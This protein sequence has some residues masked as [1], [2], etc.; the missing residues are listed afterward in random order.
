MNDI[1][2]KLQVRCTFYNHAATFIVVAPATTAVALK[3]IVSIHFFSIPHILCKTSLSY[4]EEKKNNITTTKN[5]H[6]T[7]NET[8]SHR[9]ESNMLLFSMSLGVFM[10][11]KLYLSDR[12]VSYVL[13][14]VCYR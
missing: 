12:Y 10:S 8:T 3:Q 13:S 1:L 11:R 4:E 9:F 7:E 14:C 6:Y 5:S 2:F